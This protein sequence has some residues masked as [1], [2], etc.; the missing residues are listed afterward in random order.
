MMETQIDP[1]KEKVSR[2]DL[3]YVPKVR[4]LKDA[5]YVGDLSKKDDRELLEKII[6]HYGTDR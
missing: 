1:F 4:D 3:Q 2:A 5:M 6:S